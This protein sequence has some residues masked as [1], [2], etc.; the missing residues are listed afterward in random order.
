MNNKMLGIVA[1]VAMLPSASNAQLFSITAS[2]YLGYDWTVS[3][4]GGIPHGHTDRYSYG[5]YYIDGYASPDGPIFPIGSWAATPKWYGK[6]YVWDTVTRVGAGGESRASLSPSFCTG[7]TQTTCRSTTEISFLQ[8]VVGVSVS[9]AATNGGSVVL[10]RAQGAGWETVM[11]AS[12]T[13]SIHQFLD[14]AG[15]WRV[16]GDATT[17]STSHATDS[18]SFSFDLT[19][20]EVPSFVGL[21]VPVALVGLRRRA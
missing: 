3:G 9:M 6:V 12:G 10:Q 5:S 16:V 18:K 20:P 11:A 14:M 21:L 17:F 19:V 1:A 2:M 15:R 8:G 7:F 13:Q 4:D